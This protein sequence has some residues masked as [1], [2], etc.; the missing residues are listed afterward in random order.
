MKI[1]TSTTPVMALHCLPRSSGCSGALGRPR[2]QK[3]R[4]CRSK[5]GSSRGAIYLHNCFLGGGLDEA[6]KTR[7]KLGPSRPRLAQHLDGRR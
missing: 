1:P 4:R 6:R 3:W 7:T 2:I 5:S